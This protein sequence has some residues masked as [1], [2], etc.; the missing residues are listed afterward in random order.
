MRYVNRMRLGLI[1]VALLAVVIGLVG[2]AWSDDLYALRSNHALPGAASQPGE[3]GGVVTFVADLEGADPAT[4]ERSPGLL[5]APLEPQPAAEVV[6]PASLRPTSSSG[7]I[8]ANRRVISF[9]GHPYD[10][11]MGILGQLSDDELV[12]ALYRRAAMYEELSDRPV[13]PAIHIIATVAQDNPGSDGLYRARTDADVIQHYADLASA[14]DMLLFVDVQ[15]G[16]STV[17]DEVAA[18]MPFLTQWNVHLALDPEFDMWG[19]DVPGDVIGTM[20]ADE[21]NYAQGVLSEIVA[22]Q[23][24]PNKILIVHQ[25]T[26]DMVTG[27]GAIVDD[28]NVDLVTDM[29]GF[30]TIGLKLKHYEW[31][32]KDE[33]IEYAGIKLFFDQDTP[34]MTP[35]Q[36]MRIDPVPD[37]IIYQ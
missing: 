15:V 16:Q 13:Q 34:L 33:L 3:S 36:V 25:F 11:R 2:S 7:S 24:G 31:Y 22:E 19:G 10:G 21:I 12:S 9:Y 29:D 30:G 6:E 26:P 37:V 28:P 8:L 32:V 35:E 5:E 23:G 18:V 17:R 4:N 14:N 1:I 27:K 20:T